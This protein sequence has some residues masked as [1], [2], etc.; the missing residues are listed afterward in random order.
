[1][2][3]SR[4]NINTWKETAW[5]GIQFKAPA[6]WDLSRIGARYLMLENEAGPVLE[7]K[8]AAIKGAF[9]HPKHLRRLTKSFQRQSGIRIAEHHL[10]HGWKKKLK[11][12][13][14]SGFLWTGKSMRGKGVILYC[15][16]CKHATLIQ[17]YDYPV[18]K[19]ENV[20]LE[21]LSTFRDHRLDNEAVWAVFDIRA[22][23]PDT[24][25]LKYHRFEPGR[26]ELSFASDT[27][28]L[29]LYRLFLW[30]V[31]KHLLLNRNLETE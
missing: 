28:K 7:L 8:W 6:G 3:V 20:Y 9:S 23:I 15:P 27:Q 16:D 13:D 22:V 21:I 10:P 26:F 29:T 1:M 19:P 30:I 31:P 18:C 17:F 2:V 11:N 14:V 5:N 25:V 24:Y 4:Q 12:Y